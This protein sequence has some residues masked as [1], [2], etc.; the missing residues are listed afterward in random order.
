MIIIS[1]RGINVPHLTHLRVSPLDSEDAALL[2]SNQVR[3]RHPSNNLV[4]PHDPQIHALVQ[5]VDCLPAALGFLA[6]QLGQW[7]PQDLLEHVSGGAGLPAGILDA[8]GGKRPVSTVLDSSWQGLDIWSRSVLSASALFPR[9]F[10]LT[11]LDEL[12]IL[13]DP[14]SPWLGDVMET[15]CRASLIE[16]VDSKTHTFRLLGITRTYVL[17]Q[18]PEHPRYRRVATRFIHRMLR[19]CKTWALELTTEKAVQAADELQSRLSILEWIR[20]D[21]LFSTPGHRTTATLVLGQ[22]LARKG[23]MEGHLA[24]LD[25]VFETLTPEHTLEWWRQKA[26]TQRVVGQVNA[27]EKTVERAFK[28][29]GSPTYPIGYEM[30]CIQVLQGQFLPGMNTCEQGYVDAQE[31]DDWR[32]MGLFLDRQATIARHRGDYEEAESLHLRAIDHLSASGSIWD[33]AEARANYGLV[34]FK[35]GHLSAAIRAYERALPVARE[36][37]NIGAEAVILSNLGSIL[38]SMGAHEHAK[39]KLQE[40]LDVCRRLGQPIRIATTYFF[41]GRLDADMAEWSSASDRLDT[42]IAQAQRLGLPRLEAA[43]HTWRGLVAHIQADEP[44]AI[45]AYGE[46]KA[47]IDGHTYEDL[48]P[49][50]RFGRRV[51]GAS[52][53]STERDEVHPKQAGDPEVQDVLRECARWFDTSARKAHP[54]RLDTLAL[55]SERPVVSRSVDVRFAL[56]LVKTITRS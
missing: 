44:R 36:V 51:L 42:A 16:P 17:Q 26:R 5:G 39:T 37:M 52:S 49:L 30:A 15:L 11:E 9:P 2:L 20:D 28:T 47:L 41:L 19:M 13:F 6:S 27:A 32:Y 46:A 54:D 31:H 34:H 33:E 38:T 18:M 40:S 53:K 24:D 22:F 43:A 4:D 45:H 3:E 29:I 21:R 25:R 48:K 10:T 14:N 12:K 56:R 7:T 23:V 8:Q 1:T 50:L 35:R 55:L